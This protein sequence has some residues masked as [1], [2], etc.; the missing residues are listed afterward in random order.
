MDRGGLMRHLFSGVNRAH[1]PQNLTDLE[2]KHIP[3]VAC[4]PQVAVGERFAVTVEVGGSPAPFGDRGHF[5][6]FI[7][8]YADETYLARVSLTAATT[9]PRVSLTVCLS[10]PAER[11]RAFARCNL[12]GVWVGEV[13]IVVRP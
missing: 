11:L 3:A 6:E 5:I 9:T 8:L 4:P 2:R 13:P 1:D 7:D 10:A 12:H